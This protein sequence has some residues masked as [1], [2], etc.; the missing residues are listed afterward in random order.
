[1]QYKRVSFIKIISA[2]I[3]LILIIPG[4]AKRQ[5]VPQTAAQ[6]EDQPQVQLED[7]M[8]AKDTAVFISHDE[9]NETIRLLNPGNN[10]VYEVYYDRLTEFYDRFGKVSVIE[11]F[12]TGSVVDVD[13]SVHSKR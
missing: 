8:S 6:T 2:L 9:E 13:I 3:I 10:K 7:K 5:T 4:C 12:D 1:M 11:L